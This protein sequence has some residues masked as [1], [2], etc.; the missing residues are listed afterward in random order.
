MGNAPVKKIIPPQADGTK[1]NIITSRGNVMATHVIHCTNAHVGHLVPGLRSRVVPLRGHMSAQSPGKALPDLSSEHSWSFHYTHGFDYLTQLPPSYP[2]T[3]PLCTGGEMMLGGGVAQAVGGGIYDMGVA[4]DSLPFDLHTK[5]HLC[6]ALRAI[7]A[8]DYWGEE[9]GT[10]VKSMWTGNMG[11][12]TDGLPF[13]GRLPVSLTGRDSMVASK[14]GAEWVA[15]GFSG[16]GMVHAWRSGVAVAQMVLEDI[17]P[18]NTSDW[19]EWLPTEM[20]IT[21]ERIKDATFQPP[22]RS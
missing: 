13:V 6:G 12:S 3:S 9:N 11:F 4:S 2:S 14:T 16:E 21:E 22:P 10:A 20:E 1:F 17:S 15:A 7:F 8:P 19:R 18:E 5:I